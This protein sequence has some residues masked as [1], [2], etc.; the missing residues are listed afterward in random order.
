MTD[1]RWQNFTKEELSCHHCG[2]LIIVPAFMDRLQALRKDYGKPIKI[3]SGYRCSAHN[4]AVSDTGLTGPH[5][6]GRAVDI[7][8]SGRDAY[9]LLHLALLHG[10]KGI[11]ISQKGDHGKRFLHLDDIPD[12]I[13]RPAIWSY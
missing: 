6:T 13:K 10:F 2:A 7:Q 8:I 12:T 9:D 5:T 4:K 3:T 1:W 11:G